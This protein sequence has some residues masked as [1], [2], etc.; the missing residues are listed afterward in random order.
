MACKIAIGLAALALAAGAVL[1]VAV[2]ERPQKIG[3]YEVLTPITHSNLTIFPV[4]AQRTHDTGLFLTLDEGLRSGEVVVTEAGRLQPLIRRPRSQA[5]T[6]D[7]AEVNRLVLVNNSTRPLL[8]LAGEIVVG[9]KQDRVVAQDRI[10]PAKSEPVDLSVFCVE[11]GR[12]SERS[13]TFAISGQIAAPSVRKR[14]MAE[15]NQQA[16]WG[17]VARSQA[18]AVTVEGTAPMVESTTSYATAMGDRAVQRKLDQVAVPVA[19]SYEGVLRQLRDQKAV[20]VVVAVNGQVVWADLFASTE[21]LEKYWPKLVRSY[22]AEAFVAAGG[23]TV[24]SQKEAQRFLGD[25]NGKREVV[26]TDPGVYQHAEVFGSGYR[27][28]ELTSL[29]PK[30]GFLVHAS[31]MQE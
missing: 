15:K 12:W 11:Q 2:D 5:Q 7:A 28:F 19:R 13:A 20:G 6:R 25:W 3:G 10:I 16:V 18:E 9:G 30:T 4:V 27:A 22:A 1:A 17:E 26:E 23:G 29:L 31:K 24:P 21:L 8:L 14:A